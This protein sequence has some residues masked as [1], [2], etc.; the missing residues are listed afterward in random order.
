M[1]IGLSMASG[2]LPGLLVERRLA[3]AARLS[4]GDT[5]QVRA[6]EG[7]LRAFTVAGVFEREPD[8]LR[9]S[10]NDYEVRLHLA[11]L[12]ALGGPRDRVDRIAIVLSP[13]ADAAS[14]AAWIER[15]AL[16]SRVFRAEALADSASATFR[17]VARFNDAIGFVTLLASAIF[18]LCLMIIRVDERRRDMGVLRLIGIGRGTVFRTV[19]LEAVLIAVLGSAAGAGI[20]MAAASVVNR[21]YA[22][23]YDTTL[24]FAL[25]TP[26][27]VL[28]AAALGLVL[29]L[30]AGGLA[31][32]RVAHTAPRR[33]GER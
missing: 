17:V 24:R 3:E 23:V 32:A 5:V 9:I 14:T 6:P 29:G 26:R 10:R 19:M 13:G 27:I 11:D 33:L 28:T 12:E 31:A 30:T 18:L 16:G 1:P 8:P 15:T 7:A 2:Q 4:P 21:H 20:G 22:R 25:V